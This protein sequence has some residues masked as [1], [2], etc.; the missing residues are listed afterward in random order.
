MIK[1]TLAFTNPAHL[2]LKNA[3]MVIDTRSDRGVLTRPI[4][5]IGVVM[6]ESHCVTI[7]SALLAALLA[8][9]TAVIVCDGKHIFTKPR[10]CSSAYRPGVI[11]HTTRWK[12]VH[13]AAYRQ[14]VF[15]DK[16]L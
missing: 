12:G 14:A 1:Q 4:E 5:D 2:S 16:D 11:N 13:H 9:N 15:G 7:T 8:N 10:K 6:V 3:Q